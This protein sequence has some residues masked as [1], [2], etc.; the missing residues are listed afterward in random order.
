MIGSA[1]RRV[2]CAPRPRL[3]R[4]YSF[5][6]PAW[7]QY[8][9]LELR[10]NEFDRASAIY[11]RWIGT[12][13]EPKNWNVWARFE[14]DRGKPDKAREVYQT[15]LE[16]FGDS[17]EEVE[18]AQSVFAAFAKMET[19]LKEFDRARA[20]YKVSEREWFGWLWMGDD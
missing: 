2:A 20:I 3:T 11:E 9:K 1:S 17:E 4:S 15:A 7:Q 19:R 6:I 16:F 10:Y 12:R 13:P 5:P 14:E 8:I 18:K